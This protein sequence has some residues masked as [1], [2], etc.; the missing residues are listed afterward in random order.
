MDQCFFFGQK[1]WEN[2]GKYF[3]SSVNLSKFWKFWKFSPNW[4]CQKYYYYYL[5][6]K[7]IYLF[8]YLKTLICTEIQ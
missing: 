2:L 6:F 8:I 3:I 4:G 5:K 7:F 1:D